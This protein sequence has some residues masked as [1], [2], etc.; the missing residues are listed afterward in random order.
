MKPG[1]MTRIMIILTVLAGLALTSC[2]KLD[3]TKT[4]ILP[5]P[6]DKWMFYDNGVNYTGISANSGGD[7]DIAI[8]FNSSQLTDYDGYEIAE[9]KFYP[10]T[11]YPAD[12]SVTIWEGSEPPTLLHLQSTSV[13][14]G[15]WNTVYIDQYLYLDASKDL[16]AGIWIQDYPAGTYPAGCD[17]G[18]AVAGKGDLY[19]IDDGQTWY[20]LFNSDGLNYNWNLQVYLDDLTGKK[21]VL[22]SGNDPAEKLRKEALRKIQPKITD[23][24]MIL[25]K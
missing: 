7:F 6:G 10:V 17:A 2:K 16:W 21:K 1:Y 12:Y 19:S 20:S 13:I 4:E 3:F 18:P 23:N 25:S 24:R 5:P 14:S 9:V 11:G 8:R 15:M 22:T